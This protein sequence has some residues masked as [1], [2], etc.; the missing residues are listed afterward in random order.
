MS[1]GAKELKHLKKCIYIYYCKY[2]NY[3]E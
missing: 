2:F 1:L 3:V